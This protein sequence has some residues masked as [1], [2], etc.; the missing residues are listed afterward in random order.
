MVELRKKIL[1]AHRYN[2]NTIIL[3]EENKRDLEDIPESVRKKLD[4]HFV[5]YI[6]EVISLSLVD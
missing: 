6:P 5:K 4:I 3:P 1:A 2:I